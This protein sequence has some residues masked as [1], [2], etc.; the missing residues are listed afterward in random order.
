MAFI[1]YCSNL[2]GTEDP[3]TVLVEVDQIP[4]FNMLRGQIESARAANGRQAEENLGQQPRLRELQEAIR[5]MREGGEV[6]A[7]E[8]ELALLR[9]QKHEREQRYNR[10]TLRRTLRGATAE[11]EAVCERLASQ[12]WTGGWQDADGCRTGAERYLEE[13]MRHLRRQKLTEKLEAL[14]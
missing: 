11:A 9:V 14:R 8:A 6:E 4:E 5:I 1:T 2:G 12:P 10:A 7:A 3:L 13:K